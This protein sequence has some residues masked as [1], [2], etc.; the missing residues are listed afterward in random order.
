M[1]AKCQNSCFYGDGQLIDEQLLL[2]LLM[3]GAVSNFYYMTVCF[4]YFRISKTAKSG[5]LIRSIHTNVP[6]K[7]ADYLWLVSLVVSPLGSLGSVSSC[8]SSPSSVEP[9]THSSHW[10]PFLL[11]WSGTGLEEIQF[12]RSLFFCF[13]ACAALHTLPVLWAFD[14]VVIICKD[15]RVYS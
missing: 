11:S 12:T 1:L 8:T 13:I 9:E 3:L 2:T 14:Q 7:S 10:W 5:I 4:C 6:V 15:I